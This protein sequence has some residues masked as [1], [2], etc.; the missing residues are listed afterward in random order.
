M[1]VDRAMVED[2]LY[3]EADL[4]DRWELDA[5]LELFDD[6]CRYVIPPA[7]VSDANPGHDAFMVY[8]DRAMLEH[9]VASLLKRSAHAEWPHSRTRRLV[10]NVRVAPDADGSIV[11]ANFTVHRIRHEKVATFIGRYE[12]RLVDRNGALRFRERTAHLDLE[13]LRPEGKVSIIL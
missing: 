12:H 13:A 6:P 11:A 3:H 1:N 4:L 5:W 10:T 9:R 7:G 8:D 2:F